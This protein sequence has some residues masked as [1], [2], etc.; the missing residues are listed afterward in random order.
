MQRIA[1]GT[2][3]ATLPTFDAPSGTPGFFGKTSDNAPAPTRISRDWLNS[4]QEELIAVILAGGL[5]PS[6]TLTQVRDAIANM[7]AAGAA[8][9]GQVAFFMRPTPPSGWLVMDTSAVSRVT[10]SSL[11][12]LAA[13]AGYSNGWGPGDGSTTFNLP[14][15]RGIF[16]R[17]FDTG[18]SVDPGRVFGSIQGFATQSHNHANGVAMT[19]GSGANE[20][21]N[22]GTT[23]AN[24]PGA[25]DH[26]AHADAN[27]PAVQGYTSSGS[28]AASGGTGGPVGTF[29]GETR[30]IN[31]AWLFCIKY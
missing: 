24:T 3:R 14:D 30:P 12:A 18:G 26:T 11:N 1:N 25:A 31:G 9:A 29:A 16:P 22:Y 19:L 28:P 21:Y 13:A 4:V 7:I 8:A 6:G 15:G 27:T 2:Q 20:A 10:Y 17:G 5:T 23:G